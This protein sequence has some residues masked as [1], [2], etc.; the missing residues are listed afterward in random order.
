MENMV[1]DL[2]ASI[3]GHN[4]MPYIRITL[5]HINVDISPT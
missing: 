2:M 3:Q 1:I 5:K 4:S